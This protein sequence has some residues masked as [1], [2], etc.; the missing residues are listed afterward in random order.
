MRIEIDQ[1]D[2]GALCVCAL[3]Y[4]FGRRFYMSHRIQEIVTS[5][6]GELADN[7]IKTILLDREDQE[8]MNLWGD[9]CDR[10]DWK[11]FY[12]RVE[13]EL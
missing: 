6:L 3:R 4:C 1:Q 9:D 8:A 11:R 7:T 2:L 13:T 10:K 12:A 5:H